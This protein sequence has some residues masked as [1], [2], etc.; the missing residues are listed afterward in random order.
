MYAQ[1]CFGPSKLLLGYANCKTDEA[2]RRDAAADRATTRRDLRYRDT[3]T[4]GILFLMG[5]YPSRLARS[6]KYCL[7]L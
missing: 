7:P 5:S 2:T 3:A 4:D 1:V 6:L